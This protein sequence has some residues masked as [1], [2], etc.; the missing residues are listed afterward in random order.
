MKEHFFDFVASEASKLSEEQ[1]HTLKAQVFN[2]L[3][4]VTA[5]NLKHATPS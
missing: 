5:S 4:N 3:Q 2:A 1:Y